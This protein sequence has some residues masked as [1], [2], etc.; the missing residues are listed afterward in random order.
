MTVALKKATPT[1]LVVQELTRF[2]ID[3]SP[4]VIC[5]RG[6]WGVGKT[7]AW[8][9]ALKEVATNGKMA[10]SAYSYV[11]LFGIT[12]IEQLKYAIFENRTSGEAIA[13]GANLESVS[14]GI[15]DL[16]KTLG[17]KVTRNSGRN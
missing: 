7:Y 6:R 9:K 4:E 10:F 12:T 15:S 1:E 8:K 17:P 5:V 16:I 2:L 13:T 14:T 11:S 3:T